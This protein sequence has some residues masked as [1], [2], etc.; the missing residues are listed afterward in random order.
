MRCD[1]RSASQGHGG[2][3]RQ[4]HLSHCPLVMDL[5][6]VHL[7]CISFKEAKGAVLHTHTQQWENM[8]WHTCKI[9]HMLRK[10]KL[11]FNV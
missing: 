9:K 11:L 4:S 3:A 2:L 8:D 6:S 5:R 7:A 1:F 10:A